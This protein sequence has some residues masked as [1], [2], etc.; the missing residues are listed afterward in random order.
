MAPYS[1]DAICGPALGCTLAPSRPCVRMLLCRTHPCVSACGAIWTPRPRATGVPPGSS[2]LCP[3]PTILDLFLASR[4]ALLDHLCGPVVGP[5]PGKVV[6]RSGPESA[7]TAVDRCPWTDW[8]SWTSFWRIGVGSILSCNASALDVG[9][10]RPDTVTSPHSLGSI[11]HP[12]V[13]F[14]G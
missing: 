9:S 4:T 5:G 13:G 1:P 14:R 11:L 12:T 10:S 8:T 7:L 3:G 2:W 6:H